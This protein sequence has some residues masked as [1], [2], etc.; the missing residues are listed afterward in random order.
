VHSPASHVGRETRCYE[1]YRQSD[2]SYYRHLPLGFIERNIL[3]NS[4]STLLRWW[5]V[6]ERL[7][8]IAYLQITS[9]WSTTTTTGENSNPKETCFV[10]DVGSLLLV[11]SANIQTHRHKDVLMISFKVSI[12]ICCYKSYYGNHSKV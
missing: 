8:V 2:Q 5:R 3:M 10:S 9:F 12:I 4:P 1:Y 11:L 7:G 6:G